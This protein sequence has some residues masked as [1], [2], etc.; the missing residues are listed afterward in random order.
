MVNIY[1]KLIW[2]YEVHFFKDILSTTS[3][4]KAFFISFVDEGYEE[5]DFSEDCSDGETLDSSE[6]DEYDSAEDSADRWRISF[7]MKMNPLS[8]L[9]PRK[10]KVVSII[11]LVMILLLHFFFPSFSSA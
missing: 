9:R 6:E 2:N 8:H 4:Y 7:V 11:L 10:A 1:S 3:I 5:A